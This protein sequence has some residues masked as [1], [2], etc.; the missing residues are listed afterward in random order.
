MA[1]FCD[2]IKIQLSHDY[3]LICILTDRNIPYSNEEDWAARAKAWAATQSG[4]ENHHAQSQ[5]MPVGRVDD[6]NYA[7]HDQYQQAGGPRDVSQPSVQQ[8]SN[9]QFPAGMMDSLKQVND[10]HGS[11][12]NS[13]TSSYGTG[14][15]AGA[16]ATLTGGDHT[17]SPQK[18]YRS[19]SSVYEQEVSY[20]YSSAP[21]NASLA[22]GF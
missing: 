4:S 17:T 8:L 21:G 11:T 16:E 5:F 3:F 12:F 10:L 14:Y 20:S 15:S 1:V 18:S 22:F 19:S 7:Y 9:H 13:G 2:G 6:R